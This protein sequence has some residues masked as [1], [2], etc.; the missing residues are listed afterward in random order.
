M[1]E[2]EEKEKYAGEKKKRFELISGKLDENWRAKWISEPG[3]NPKMT[4]CI[5]FHTNAL[6][7]IMKTSLL[8]T[9]LPVKNQA[10]FMGVVQIKKGGIINS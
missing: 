3:S 5:C 7:K 2:I 6:V 1:E 9:M 4:Y 8:A 10:E